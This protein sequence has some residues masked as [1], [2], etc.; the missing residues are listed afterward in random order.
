MVSALSRSARYW[1]VGVSA[2]STATVGTSFATQRYLS[3]SVR[4]LDEQKP[5]HTGSSEAASSSSSTAAEGSSRNSS[6][7]GST[8]YKPPSRATGTW[9][10]ESNAE[11][12]ESNA[13]ASASEASSPKSNPYAGLFDGSDPFPKVGDSSSSSSGSPSTDPIQDGAA[14]PK[15]GSWLTE[16]LD[17][18]SSTSRTSRVIGRS[19]QPNPNQK[20]S[21]SERRKHLVPRSVLF[22]DGEAAR[23]SDELRPRKPSN[24]PRKR[25]DRTPLTKQEANAF[26]SLLNQALAGTSSPSS[27]AAASMPGDAA[28]D[29][30]ALPFG[31]YTSLISN[32]KTQTGS[33]ALLQAFAKR[34][35]LQR[36]EA[37]KA[38]RARR[39]AREGL[40]A[41]IDPLL[42]EAGIDEAREH[43]AMCENLAELLDF[44]KR[45]VWGIRP[46]TPSTSAQDL[47]A[48]TSDA[49]TGAVESD[50]SKATMAAP[51]Y[52]EPKYGKDTPYYSSVLQLLFVAIRDRYRAPHVALSLPRVTRSLGIES[53]VLGV[54]G[55]LYNEVLK[56]Q[57]DWLGDLQGVVKTLRQARETGI[58]SAPLKHASIPPGSS[59]PL[60]ATTEDETIR[61]TVDRIANEV[62]KFVLDQQMAAHPALKRRHMYGG[63][64]DDVLGGAAHEA[65]MPKTELTEDWSHT[66]L[67]ANADEASALA[68]QPF[69]LLQRQADDADPGRASGPARGYPKKAIRPGRDNR[70]PRDRTSPRQSSQRY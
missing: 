26:M 70:E 35:R 7:S 30:S 21:E 32:P 44:A 4:H 9:P 52:G 58:L 69:R 15:T 62:R 46:N 19:A 17:S 33:K 27:S 34:N 68:G 12:S 51:K 22:A 3:A 50:P 49:T 10:F 45:E 56:T 31:S 36:F 41:Q 16:Q 1:G 42:L 29:S 60:Y 18:L 48:S 43:I 28:E 37:A 66:W 40:A 11:T 5:P 53:Y 2:R 23:Q 63:A 59:R 6:S 38:Q 67:L 25:L 54:T 8:G 57:W 24:S 64:L 55:L 20:M 61:E 14:L 47:G 39:F 13:Q 65:Q